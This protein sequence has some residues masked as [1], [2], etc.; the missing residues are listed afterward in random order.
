MWMEM[1]TSK[2][3]ILTT[4]DSTIFFIRRDSD[5]TLFLSPTY[6]WSDT[7]VDATLLATYCFFKVALD[8]PSDAEKNGIVLPEDISERHW[9]KEDEIT[10]RVD[11]FGVVE[12]K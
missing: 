7:G 4:Y 9:P 12:A 5:S 6:K 2:M 10:R 1:E 8:H 3:G 11:A